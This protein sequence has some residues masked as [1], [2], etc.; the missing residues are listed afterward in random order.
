M[1]LSNHIK[2]YSNRNVPISSVCTNLCDFSVAR[3]NNAHTRLGL[4]KYVNGL[5]GCITLRNYEP[6]FEKEGI[7]LHKLLKEF[8][9][10]SGLTMPEVTMISC[11]DEHIMEFYQNIHYNYKKK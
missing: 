2:Y 3:M 7:N 8:N 10:D 9:I 4:W 11:S 5:E 1:K 6:V